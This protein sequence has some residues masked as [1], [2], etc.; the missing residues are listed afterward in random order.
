MA[1]S[2]DRARNDTPVI[3]QNNLAGK[4]RPSSREQSRYLYRLPLRS[5]ARHL[6]AAR[7]PWRPAKRPWCDKPCPLLRFWGLADI[8]VLRIAGSVSIGGNFRRGLVLPPNLPQPGGSSTGR[9]CTITDTAH[10]DNRGA[11]GFHSVLDDFGRKLAEES[12]RHI[13]SLSCCYYCIVT[14]NSVVVTPIVTPITLP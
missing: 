1:L 10:K 11:L 5:A 6:N 14:S 12:G 4:A 9:P 8:G 13:S 2:R 7:A 3:G